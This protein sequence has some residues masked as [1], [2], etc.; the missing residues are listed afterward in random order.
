MPHSS[1]KKTI[2]VGLS[3]K[4]IRICRNPQKRDQR[5]QEMRKRLMDRGYPKLL[6]DSAIERARQ[7]LRKGALKR[8]NRQKKTKGPIFAHTYDSRL[9]QWPRSRQGIREP[10]CIKTHI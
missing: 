5:L 6:L 4:I 8:V 7:I 1:D 2:P 9:P 3:M 10:W